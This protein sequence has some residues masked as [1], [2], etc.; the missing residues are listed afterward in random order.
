MRIDTDTVKILL[1]SEKIAVDQLLEIKR[2]ELQYLKVFLLFF[3]AITTWIISQWLS[4][5]RL[6]ISNMD[7]DLQLDLIKTTY[8]FSYFA[9]VIFLSCFSK[10]G[11]HIMVLLSVC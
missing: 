7:I 2:E 6:P 3:G 11:I 1:Q 4:P 8:L 5:S 9:T 10:K